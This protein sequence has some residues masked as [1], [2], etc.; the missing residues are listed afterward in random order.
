ME[1]AR[2]YKSDAPELELI[3]TVYNINPN[4]NQEMLSHCPVLSEYQFFVEK[5]REHGTI[6]ID[7]EESVKNAIDYC[8]EHHILEEFLKERG[9]E[10]LHNMTFDF[11]YERHTK[12]LE[13][14]LEE[15]E[16]QITE[17]EQQIIE[18]EQQITEQ[19][20]QINELLARIQTLEKAAVK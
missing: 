9:M 2:E 8:I 13:D 5:V 7:I 10:V 6:S 12:F 14:E 3:C 18:Q 20:Q 15:K 1:H 17:Q 4:K 11:T 19:K 16:Q